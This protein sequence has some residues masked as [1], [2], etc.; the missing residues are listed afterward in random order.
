MKN[1]PLISV[2]LPVY[3]AAP[4]I[5]EAI[6]SI[7]SQ[8]YRHFELIVINDGSTDDSGQVIASIIDPRIRVIEQANGGLPVALNRAI[9][10]AQGA[11]LARQDAD[12]ISLPLRFERQVEYLE[13]HPQCG[14]VGTWAEIKSDNPKVAK[15]HT[16]PTGSVVLKFELLFDNPF[17]HSS[18]LIRRQA[19]ER[20]G[21]YSA[22][23]H[24]RPAED[25]ELWC[26]VA[27]EFEVANLPEYLQIYRDTPN[28]MS[29]GEINPFLESVVNISIDNLA[30]ITKRD[31]C[32]PAINDLAAL[33]HGAYHRVRGHSS[34]HDLTNVLFEAADRLSLAESGHVGLLQQHVQAHCQ[35]VGHHYDLYRRYHKG[36]RLRRS[37]VQLSEMVKNAMS[38]RK[39]AAQR[40]Q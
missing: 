37:V 18:M 14:M 10:V 9:G 13:T 7:L 19:I 6:E 28:S 35:T 25:Y 32:D 21:L 26:R 12:D 33:T 27:R 17:V 31:T 29:K 40:S 34:L 30:W 38:L 8:T 16:H 2:L 1:E 5:R 11:Y 20:V 36:G 24:I 39:R 22:E 23:K 15:A 4:Y 3:N